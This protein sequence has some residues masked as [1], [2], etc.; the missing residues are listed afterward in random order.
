MDGKRTR[1]GSGT[2]EEVD[3]VRSKVVCWPANGT[4]DVASV[5]TCYM[6][7]PSP[8]PTPTHTL[9]DTAQRDPRG[10]TTSREEDDIVIDALYDASVIFDSYLSHT[11]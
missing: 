10:T 6:V 4:D 8:P 9:L 1:A 2:H 5:M 3:E 11:S 7:I